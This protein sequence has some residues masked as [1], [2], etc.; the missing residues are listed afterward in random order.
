MRKSENINLL[1]KKF[2]KL[3]ESNSIN[4]ALILLEKII[5][6]SPNNPIFLFQAAINYAKI[7]D[8]ENSLINFDKLDNM[9]KK[10][11]L[12]IYIKKLPINKT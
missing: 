3:I 4:N 2:I 8:F 5:N 1:Y 9:H 11:I 6:K 7:G 10:I 12:D